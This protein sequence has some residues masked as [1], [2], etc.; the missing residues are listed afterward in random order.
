MLRASLP[1]GVDTMPKSRPPVDTPYI[2]RIDAAGFVSQSVQQIDKWIAGGVL[3]P[4]KAGRKI[5]LR[6][7]E[8]IG[9]LEMG[10]LPVMPRPTKK[11]KVRP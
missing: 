11:G 2:S 7:A 3:H 6:K 10:G 4:L 8:L 1:A 5:L 9:K